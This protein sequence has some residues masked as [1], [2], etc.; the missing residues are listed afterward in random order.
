MESSS[1]S[2]FGTTI[3]KTAL[4]RRESM[5]EKVLVWCREFAHPYADANRIRFYGFTP[6][7][8]HQDI[9]ARRK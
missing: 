2:F 1:L 3:F 9:S 7:I 4:R 6:A 5:T 8:Y